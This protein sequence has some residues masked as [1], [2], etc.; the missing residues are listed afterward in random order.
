MTSLYSNSI[1]LDHKITS[2]ILI[3]KILSRLHYLLNFKNYKYYLRKVPVFLQTQY[4]LYYI[5]LKIKTIRKTVLPS[6]L[7]R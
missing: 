4:I 3:T 2:L 6:I 5:I 1:L 7:F